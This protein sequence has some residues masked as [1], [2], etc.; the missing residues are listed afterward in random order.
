MRILKY[1]SIWILCSCN[2]LWAQQNAVLG[3]D[4]IFYTYQNNNSEVNDTLGKTSVG[5]YKKYISK[6]ISANCEFECSC[7]L[8][9]NHAINRFGLVKGFLLGIDRLSRCGAS[10]DTYN[11]LPSLVGKNENTLIDEVHFYD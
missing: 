4:S 10:H 1:V 8:F 7:S 5:V 11:Y 6:Q 9:M 2:N 3:I